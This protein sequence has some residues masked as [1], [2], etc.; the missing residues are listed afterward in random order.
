LDVTVVVVEVISKR[1]GGT[2]AF[3]PNRK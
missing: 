2:P 3:Q 1:A